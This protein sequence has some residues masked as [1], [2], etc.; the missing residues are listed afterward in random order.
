M[1]R[2]G[3]ELIEL[4]ERQGLVGA[5]DGIIVQ[6]EIGRV[7][8]KIAGGV[9]EYVLAQSCGRQGDG[10]ARDDRPGA[11]KGAG[12]VRREVRVAVDEGDAFGARG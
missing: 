5:D 8:G 2:G 1:S 6:S 3:A 9:G 10:L 11:C 4:A 12:I 7:A